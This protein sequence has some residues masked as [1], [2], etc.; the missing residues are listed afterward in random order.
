MIATWTINSDGHRFLL[1]DNGIVDENGKCNAD[2]RIVIFA[3][4]EVLLNLAKSS[5]WMMDGNFALAPVIFQQLYVIRVK[6]N[7]YIIV[8]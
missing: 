3:T 2:E 7:I 1:Y 5:T 6:V 8:L 4:D